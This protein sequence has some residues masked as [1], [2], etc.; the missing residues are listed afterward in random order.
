MREIKHMFLDDRCIKKM[1]GTKL[2]LNQPQKY[3][4]NPV[5][6]PGTLWEKGKEVGCI[7]TLLYDEEEKLFKAWYT[8]GWNPAFGKEQKYWNVLAYAVSTDGINWE[9][10]NLGLVEFRGSKNNNILFEKDMNGIVI[11]DPS[12]TRAERKY[13]MV[14]VLPQEGS[15]AGTYQSLH[16]AYSPDGINW[17]IP[18]HKEKHWPY[19][20]HSELPFNTNPIM[21]EGTDAVS[22]YSWYWDADLRRYVALLRPTWNVP[23]CVC[24]SESDDF[25][26]WTPRKTILAP[27]EQDPDHVTNFHGFT[28]MKYDEYYIGLIQVFHT[29]DDSEYWLTHHGYPSDRKNNFGCFD[30]QLA[31]SYDGRNWKRA[32]N[33]DVFIPTGGE[34][35]ID[36]GLIIPIHQPFIL[37]DEIW[38]YYRA[39]QEDHSFPDILKKGKNRSVGLAK[40]RKDGFISVDA[41]K[42]GTILTR[43]LRTVPNDIFL[44]ADAN[45]GKIL[46]EVVNPPGDVIKGFSK[47]DCIPFTGDSLEHMVAWKHGKRIVSIVNEL[48]GGICLRFYLENAKLYSFTMHTNYGF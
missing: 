22:S 26:H 18:L 45:K 47:N 21:P 23:R 43:N 8:L 48:Y 44:N 14:F 15:F 38:I 34:N 39:F 3:Q 11:K 5:I 28:V 40:L 24:M 13:K 36:S 19:L 4:G 35:S 30:I 46:V 12:E 1:D 27:D 37:N 2:V 16:A 17:K 7:H 42:E 10:P 29:Y 33:R 41:K 25:V 20:F 6:G 32:G 31:I 9:K